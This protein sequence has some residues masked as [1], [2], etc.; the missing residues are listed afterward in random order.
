MVGLLPGPLRACPAI[1]VNVYFV[2][3]SARHSK[4]FLVAT[5][6]GLLLVAHIASGAATLGAAFIAISSK[7]ADASHRWHVVSGRVFFDGMAG[8][9]A[10]ALA[11]SLMRMNTPMLFVSVFS[12][13]FAWMG[14]RY[15]TNRAGTPG[16]SDGILTSAMTLVFAAMAVYGVFALYVLGQGFGVVIVVFGVIGFLNAYGDWRITRRGG[17]RGRLRIVEHLGK[18]LGGTIAA[19]TAF[20]V[21]NAEFEPSFVVWLSPT[22]VLVP[23]IVIWSRKVKSG[24]RR[25][26]MPEA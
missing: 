25:K 9:F 7:L 15:A 18:M 13:Y 12:F 17:V 20:L 21:I 24:M 23:L 3:M 5:V 19:V 26:G 4:E 16:R 6:F 10:T 14:R 1:S 11:M 22:A 8:I 2:A